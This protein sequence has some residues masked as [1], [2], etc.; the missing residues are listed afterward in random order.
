MSEQT[1]E[2]RGEDVESAVAEGLRQLGAKRDDVKIEVIDEGRR[3]ILGL[4]SR[5]AMV[6]LTIAASEGPGTGTG[7]PTAE[8]ESLSAQGAAIQPAPQPLPIAEEETSEDVPGEAEATDEEGAG[9]PEDEETATVAI[10]IVTTLLEKM[11]FS[12]VDVTVEVS[13][14]DDKT[15]REMTIVQVKGDSLGSLIGPH[16]ETLNDIQYIARLMAGHALRRRADFLLDIDGY[17]RKRKEALTSLAQRMAHKAIERGRPITLEPMSAY[18][19]R[20][21]HMAL[22]DVEEVYTNSVGEGSERR[23]R[24]FLVE[25]DE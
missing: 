10:E 25:D 19:R 5:E 7:I 4:G 11:G 12:D 16:G 17:R 14:P 1:V 21:I 13:E 24:I 22:R 3:G 2:V 15:G 20:I 6:R 8:A 9:E 18:D 23:V